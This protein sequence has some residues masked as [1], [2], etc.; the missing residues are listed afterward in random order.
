MAPKFQIKKLADQPAS[1]IAAGEKTSM[2]MLLS[3]EE[4]PN[5]AMRCFTI[6]PGGFMPLHTNS[7]EHEQY[8]LQGRAE[9]RFGDETRTVAAGDVVFIPAGLPHSYRTLDSE[10]FRFICLVPNRQDDIRLVDD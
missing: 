6:E 2:Q 7:V 3:P 8:V 10:P 9:V 1:A 4:T 5:F